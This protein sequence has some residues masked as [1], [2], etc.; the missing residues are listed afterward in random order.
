MLSDDDDEGPRSLHTCDECGTASPPTSTGF[1]LISA[2]HRWR[3]ARE[4]KPGGGV[5]LRWYCPACW[6]AKK[7]NPDAASG[8]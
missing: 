5:T 6:D 8:E 7:H 1:T 4:P 2:Q 3:L